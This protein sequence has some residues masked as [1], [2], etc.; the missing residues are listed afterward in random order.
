MRVLFN[1]T[2]ALDGTS[3]FTQTVELLGSLRRL[4]APHDYA[5]LTTRGQ[6]V[7][8]EALGTGVEHIVIDAP[9]SGLA[10]TAFLWARL[11]GIIRRAN[12]A[13]LYNRGNFYA[14]RLPC[15]QVCLL[16]NANPF[17]NLALPESAGSRGR[18]RLLRMMSE[19]ALKYATAV[20]FPSQTAHRIVVDSRTVRAR[21]FV[22]PH[23]AEMPEPADSGTPHPALYILAV[24]SLFPFKNLSVGIRALGLL[25]AR[26]VFGGELV[27]V[28]DKGPAAYLETLKREIAHLR[29]ARVVHIRA[30]LPRSTLSGW[31]RHAALA[32]TTSL[33]ETFG[34]PV[35]EA[36]ALGTPVV[37]ADKPPTDR[38]YF[39][40]F[41]ELC[42][43]AAEYFDPF[44]AADCAAAMGRALTE[45]RRSAMVAAGLARTR[46]LTWHAAA[47]RTAEMFNALDA[48]RNCSDNARNGTTGRTP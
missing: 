14:P 30:A 2:A 26:G 6:S 45:P 15:Q 12:A 43:E 10:R 38:Q 39:L 16:E 11:P 28:G 41:R 29:L 3:G 23:G 32:L 5:V 34:L 37:A 27:I 25:R 9:A 18:N 24:A 7:L 48:S 36:M 22:I 19:A 1:T 21:T 33:E 17:S 4:P 44:D 13:L 20:V 40:P 47:V 42:D 35:V 8:R 31:Y 46:Q